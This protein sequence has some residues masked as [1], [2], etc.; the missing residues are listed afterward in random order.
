MNKYQR[1][2]T[3]GG[4]FNN[5]SDPFFNSPPDTVFVIAEN[6][7]KG[8]FV[9]KNRLK[10]RYLTPFFSREDAGEAARATSEE[11][12]EDGQGVPCPYKMSKLEARSTLRRH[13]QDGRVTLKKRC[14]TWKVTLP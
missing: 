8:G 6:T 10:K 9:V 13:G 5:P 4:L 2:V 11:E 1:T 14:A 12:D 7:A 3:K